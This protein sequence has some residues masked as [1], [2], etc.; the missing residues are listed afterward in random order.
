MI[1]EVIQSL[2]LI[3]QTKNQSL[4]H[5]AAIMGMFTV[6]TI[7]ILYCRAKFQMMVENNKSKNDFYNKITKK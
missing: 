1:K 7:V 4:L 3:Q 5:I 6:C 2:S